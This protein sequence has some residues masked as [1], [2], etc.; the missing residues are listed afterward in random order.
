MARNAAREIRKPRSPGREGER[1]KQR[2]RWKERR[3]GRRGDVGEGR[4]EGRWVRGAG[5]EKGTD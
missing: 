1:G 2:D 3:R 5:R 4:R